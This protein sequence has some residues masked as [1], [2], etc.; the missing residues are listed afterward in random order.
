METAW[1]ERSRTDNGASLFHWLPFSRHKSERSQMGT[2][3]VIE[4]TTSSF[5]AITIVEHRNQ[6]NPSNQSL[7]LQK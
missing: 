5:H 2:P 4:G 7:H 1:L 3:K 6:D